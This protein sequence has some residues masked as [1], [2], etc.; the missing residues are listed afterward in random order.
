M[1][2]GLMF[3]PV[4][5]KVRAGL[6][7]ALATQ[8]GVHSIGHDTDP[9]GRHGVALASGDQASGDKQ[10]TYRSRSVAVFDERT[11][12]LLSIQE[13]LTEPGGEYAEM[14]PGFILD[15]ETVR[16]AAWTGTKPGRPSAEVPFGQR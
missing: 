5:P 4:P 8:P 13:E 7:R 9:L 11:G 10:G 3:C 16:S 12:A 2:A 15:Y 6:I 14:K 1:V